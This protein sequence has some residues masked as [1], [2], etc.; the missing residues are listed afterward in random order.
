[1]SKKI[2]KAAPGAIKDVDPTDV[3]EV[4][5]KIVKIIGDLRKK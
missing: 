1:M 2:G 5:K 4:I 3:I